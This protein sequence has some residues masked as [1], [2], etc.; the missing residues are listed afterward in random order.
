MVPIILD[1]TKQLAV[2]RRLLTVRKS[3]FDIMYTIAFNNVEDEKRGSKEK[4]TARDYIL[5]YS[6][7]TQARL[8]E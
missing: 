2:K 6:I 4:Q 1:F 7:K 3:V 5:F 8:G